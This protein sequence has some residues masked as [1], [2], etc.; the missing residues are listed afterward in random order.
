MGEVVKAI[1]SS[2]ACPGGTGS[3]KDPNGYLNIEVFV[4]GLPPDCTDLHLFQI[5]SPF[6]Q[7]RANG[8]KSMIAEDGNCKGFGFVNYLAIESAQLAIQT[9]SGAQMPNNKVLRVEMKKSGGAAA[10]PAPIPAPTSFA[11]PDS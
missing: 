9:L 6:G 4:H 2:G 1:W 8:V 10:Q 11:M 5:F 7:I 3:P